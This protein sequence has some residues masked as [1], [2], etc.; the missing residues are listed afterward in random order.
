LT[1]EADETKVILGKNDKYID[2][3]YEEKES[4]KY[5]L[6]E[7]SEQIQIRGSKDDSLLDELQG[8]VARY[9]KSSR[10]SN[11]TL[12]ERSSEITKL[13]QEIRSLKEELRSIK[14]ETI[15]DEISQKGLLT[16]SKEK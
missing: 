3:L 15:R 5:Q 2:K 14:V 11:M 8:E 13:K 12:V 4:L 10:E 6:G 16:L 1:L 9:K 7:L